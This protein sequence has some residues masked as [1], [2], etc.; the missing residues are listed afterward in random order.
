MA[1]KKKGLPRCRGRP[2]RKAGAMSEEERDRAA[3][4]PSSYL[5]MSTSFVSGRKN[6]PITSV[7]AA[8]MTGYHRP[9]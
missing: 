8:T 3:P 7:M 6:V 5:E 2:S 4:F 1:V 9:E